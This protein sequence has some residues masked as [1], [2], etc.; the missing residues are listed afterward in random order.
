MRG[1]SINTH[2]PGCHTTLCKMRLE[3]KEHTS[4]SFSLSFLSPLFLL[5]SL[6]SYHQR[7]LIQFY[8]DHGPLE[9]THWVND[10]SGKL[11]T[12]G[13]STST[14]V[15]GRWKWI[16][17]F[18][19]LAQRHEQLP[20][21]DRT[22]TQTEVTVPPETKCVNKWPVGVTYRRRGEGLLPGT[23]MTQR[24]LHQQRPSRTRKQKPR[25]ST[26]L[27]VALQAGEFPLLSSPYS[28]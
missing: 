14:A 6:Q 25:A 20:S 5:A 3:T 18:L 1:I 17:V 4:V 26:V 16:E 28:L 8:M 10:F 24:Q 7:H 13:N 2:R 9:S 12:K 23:R 27:H 19:T 22:L 11:K 21:L 15:S